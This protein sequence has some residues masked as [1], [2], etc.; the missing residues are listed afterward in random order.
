[1]R[2]GEAS[3]EVFDALVSRG[4]I[5][6]HASEVERARALT[7][8][9]GLIVADTRQ[10]VATLNAAIRDHRLTGELTTWLTALLTPGLADEPGT[11]TTAA[12]EQI[13]VGDRIATRR[14][15]RGLDVANRDTWTV[16]AITA[17]A[18]LT[19]TGPPGERSLPGGVRGRA[20]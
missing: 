7:T 18:G 9:E 20:C 15:D 1:M 6:V 12:G 5:V 14:N 2:T 4:Q 13:G 17:D 11:L 3:G 8:A 10:Q 19:V 16:T